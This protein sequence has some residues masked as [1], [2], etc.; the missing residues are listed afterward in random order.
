MSEEGAYDDRFNYLS[1]FQWDTFQW[2]HYVTHTEA[3]FLL[4]LISMLTF[5]VLAD[6]YHLFILFI[7]MLDGC[8]CYHLFFLWISFGFL[9]VICGGWKRFHL[10]LWFL[11]NEGIDGGFCCNDELL[12]MVFGQWLVRE[13]FSPLNDFSFHWAYKS[14]SHPLKFLIIKSLYLWFFRKTYKSPLLVT[15]KLEWFDERVCKVSMLIFWVGG[16]CGGGRGLVVVV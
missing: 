9:F 15:I 12:Q 13:P 11:W 4:L 5:C 6:A 2:S 10:S 7:I 3:P 14:S 8:V 16:V 1:G